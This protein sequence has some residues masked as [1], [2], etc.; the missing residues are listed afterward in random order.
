MIFLPFPIK[1]SVYACVLIKDL[2]NHTQ[3]LKFFLHGSG[4]FGMPKKLQHQ[5]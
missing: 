4:H 2:V 5:L 1:Q 3:F